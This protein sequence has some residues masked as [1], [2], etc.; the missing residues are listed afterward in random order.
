[1]EKRKLVEYL[2]E[3]WTENKAKGIMAQ[4]LFKREMKSKYSRYRRKFFDGCWVLAPREKDF[5]KFRFCFFVHSRVMKDAPGE[6]TEPEDIMKEAVEGFK[7]RRI[8]SFL[9]RAGLEVIY[10]IPVGDSPL[11]PEDMRWFLY[12]YSSRREVLQQIDADAFFSQWE[13]K[14]KPGQGKTWN[15]RLIQDYLGLEE[16]EL[17]SLVLNDA[18]YTSFLKGRLRKPVSDPSDVDGFLLSFSSGIVLPLEIKEKFPAGTGNNMFFG[19][20]AGRI[21]MLLRLCLPNDT[22]ALYII[23]EVGEAER[24][25][26]GWKFMPL[27]EIILTAS[28]NLQ[29]GGK[30]MGGQETQTIKLPYHGFK[31]LESSD[32]SDSSLEDIGN[33]PQEIRKLAE[34]FKRVL[35]G[36]FGWN[37]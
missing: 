8:A 9:N 18:F 4:L 29:R 2:E 21:L 1:M 15:D 26:R 10:A 22:N 12:R 11:P 34:E 3:H 27:S 14:G 25:F 24:E 32:L 7:F 6:D 13:G 33:L 30:G 28:W 36:R 35:E 20:D 31:N 16:D 17:V 19:I 37:G 5:F 23:R